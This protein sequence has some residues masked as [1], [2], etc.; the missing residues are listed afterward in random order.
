MAKNN[1]PVEKPVENSEA[2][3]ECAML[4]EMDVIGAG[5]IPEEVKKEAEKENK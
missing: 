4:N 1:K 3:V 2:Q 5:D